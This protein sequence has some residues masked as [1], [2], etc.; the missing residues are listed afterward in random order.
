MF[1]MRRNSGAAAIGCFT[2]KSQQRQPHTG[3]APRHERDRADRSP[4]ASRRYVAS[5]GQ[6]VAGVSGGPRVASYGVTP[7]GARASR[8]RPGPYR[9]FTRRCSPA[10]IGPAAMRREVWTR[11]GSEERESE[12]RSIRC[13]RRLGCRYGGC[14]A[15]PFRCETSRCARR[16][17]RDAESSRHDARL[18]VASPPNTSSGADEVTL[19]VPLK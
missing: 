18:A 12:G 16:R 11:P 17:P 3:R 1:T 7:V 6:A 19:N 13:G 14:A 10:P 5:G 4:D 2:K 15:V 9:L 8:V